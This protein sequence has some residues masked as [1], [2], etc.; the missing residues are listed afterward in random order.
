MDTPILV[1]GTA[2]F[3]GHNL[4]HRLIEQG[5]RVI[6]YDCVNDYYPA[7]VKRAR[8]EEL[9]GHGEQYVHVE[10]DLC[11]IDTLQKT[12]ATW[13]PQRV[14]H[15][16]AQ[17][18]VPFSMREPFAYQK[19]N[20]EGFLNML[21]CCRHNGVERF[22]YASSSSVY[23]DSTAFPLSEALRVDT[24]I[25][26]YA[27][28]KKANEL[29]AHSYTHLYGLQTI[30][31]RFFTVYGPW[32]RPDMA[33]WIFAEKISNGV[34]I[35]VFNNGDL[36]RDFTYID[37]ITA[38]VD[39][40]LHKPD[41]EPYEIFNLGNN[42][43]ENVM[44]MIRTIESSLGKEAQIIMKPPQPGDVKKTWADVSKAAAKLDYAPQTPISVGIPAFCE[45]YLEH[46]E[47]AATVT[48]WRE[49]S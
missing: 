43:S 41:L 30:G 33:L 18:G 24:P 13:K 36:Q 14:C 7:A 8:L 29:M 40:V 2:G 19:S 27:A 38:G 16:A 35:P 42:Q 34:G 44:D 6:G 15:L 28:T 25:S 32:G 47:L 22:A 23:G 9:T 46:P 48:K 12:F 45:W 1:T 3:I 11:D 21:E 17:A 31:L 39:N 4:A 10:A 49:T 37:D 26:L 5:H 20:L